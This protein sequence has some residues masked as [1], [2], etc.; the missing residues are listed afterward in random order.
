MIKLHPKICFRIESFIEILLIWVWN[1]SNIWSRCTK[2]SRKI[3]M[4]KVLNVYGRGLLGS[5]MCPQKT[6]EK[7]WTGSFHTSPICLFDNL[8]ESHNVRDI[9]MAIFNQVCSRTPL[10]NRLDLY[11]DIPL[12]LNPHFNWFRFVQ[13]F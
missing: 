2:K 6:W 1:Q 13:M 5:I 7:N 3:E 11:T 9:F 4:L 8:I 10:K 12:Q